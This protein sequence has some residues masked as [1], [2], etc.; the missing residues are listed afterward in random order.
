MTEV[1]LVNMKHDSADYTSTHYK[2]G[3]WICFR[4]THDLK[5]AHDM[6][7]SLREGGWEVIVQSVLL[8]ANGGVQLD[9]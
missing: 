2:S 4:S 9:G 5:A 3:D 8:D 6:A 7:E 1:Y